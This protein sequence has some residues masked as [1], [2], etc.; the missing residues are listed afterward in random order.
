MKKQL[1]QDKLWTAVNLDV[2][3]AEYNTKYFKNKLTT[4]AVMWTTLLDDDTLAKCFKVSDYYFLILLNS[5]EVVTERQIRFTLL[6]EQCHV[7]NWDEDDD[8]GPKWKAS[9]RWLA[10]I[11]AFDDLW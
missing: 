7:A 11:G 9:M 3:F 6:H 2:W 8:H 4:T 10:S 5:K 1:K